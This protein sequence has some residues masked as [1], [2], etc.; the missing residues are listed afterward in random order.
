VRVIVVCVAAAGLMV[1]VAPALGAAGATL[2]VAPQRVEAGSVVTVSGSVGSGCGPGDRVNLISASFSHSNDFAGLP[3]VF[4]PH[5][6]NGQFSVRVRIPA[7]R[8]AGAYSITGRCGGGDLGV[9]ARL[10]VLARTAAR[11]A[12]QVAPAG[13][14]A[15]SLLTVSGSVGPGCA[16]GG[17]LT[18]I[19]HAFP[20]G[21]EFAGV[22]AVRVQHDANGR[23]SVRV[24]I[25]AQ[26]APGAYQITGRCG[27]GNLGVAAR[28]RV[29]R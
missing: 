10:R 8:A 28:V 18:L 23:F 7:D 24:R 3:A 6:A 9:A 21:Q 1:S 13:V 27:G 2:R 5:A 22:D 15:G 16:R 4:A 11:A 12:I 17:E 20:P 14:R 29:L 26:R 25:P 19:S